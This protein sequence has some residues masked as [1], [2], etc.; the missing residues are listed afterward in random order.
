MVKILRGD[1]DLDRRLEGGLV[2]ND[3]TGGAV[4]DLTQFF[5]A[6]DSGPRANAWKAG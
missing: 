3:T 2:T 1:F 6:C 5:R 4:V